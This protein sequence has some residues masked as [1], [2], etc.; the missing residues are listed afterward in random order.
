MN[1]LMTR[2]TEPSTLRGL[3]GILSAFGVAI[4]PDQMNMYVAL[5]MAATGFINT[6]RKD[7]GPN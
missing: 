4:T 1:D 2:L 7:N 3:V 5:Y 6:V